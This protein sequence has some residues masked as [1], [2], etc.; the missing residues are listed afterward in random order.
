MTNTEIFERAVNECGYELI[1]LNYSNNK[2]SY[3]RGYV[4]IGS[5]NVYV[6]WD[7]EGRC[8]DMK[9]N[10]LPSFDLPLS[11]ISEIIKRE[12]LCM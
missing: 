5:H 7:A 1:E 11:S 8:T 10:P 6:E 3:A 4:K 2:V 9:N 12:K